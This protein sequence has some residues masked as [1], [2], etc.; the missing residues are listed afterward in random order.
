LADPLARKNL[1][2]VRRS[3]DDDDD[4]DHNSQVWRKR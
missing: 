2:L 3:D 4:D 1:Q